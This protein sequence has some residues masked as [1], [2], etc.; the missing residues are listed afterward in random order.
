MD[1]AW[2]TDNAPTDDAQ[3]ATHFSSKRPILG[4]CLKR[5]SY[6]PSG[7][8]I[9]LNTHVDIPIEIGLPHFIKDDHL[10]D[11]APL[12]GNFKLSLQSVVCHRGTSVDSG[13]YI[14]LV[15][16]T[17]PNPGFAAGD[18]RTTP[19]DPKH[20][21][22]FDDL[23]S[24]RI[25]L[26]DIEKA[27]K[28]ESPYL[29]FYQILPVEG[30]PD[31]ITG[32]EEK[33]ASLAESEGKDSGV[34]GVSLSSLTLASSVDEAVTSARPSLEITGP[35][36]SRGRLPALDEPHHNVTFS[37]GTKQNGGL[38]VTTNDGA[39]G[40]ATPRNGSN[41]G[42]NNSHH[43]SSSRTSQMM[44][45]AISSLTG[46]ASRER[47]PLDG[48]GDPTVVVKEVTSLD[49]KGKAVLRKDAKRDKSKQ[50]QDRSSAGVPRGRAEKPD[51]ECVVM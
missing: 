37:E 32:G 48:A 18:V 39:S 45:D 10:G 40:A 42:R 36:N 21:M 33:P 7:R 38:A 2:Y 3:V 20:W 44:S 27:M 24:E 26:I 49:T 23:A 14:A 47:L 50:R 5:Y 16:G 1:I 12:Y 11:N 28:E 17:A 9:R 13:H 35:D 8:A 15:R 25:T 6:L 31:N 41:I 51:R 19:E 4:M 43:R 29:L 46:R 22:R 34:A 30:D